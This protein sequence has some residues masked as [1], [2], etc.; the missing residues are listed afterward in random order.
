MKTGNWKRD[1]RRSAINSLCALM[2]VFTFASTRSAAQSLPNQ[3]WKTQ[4]TFLF[5]FTPDPNTG[6]AETFAAVQ[7]ALPRLYSE[8]IRNI[9]IYGP[10]EA[11]TQYSGLDAIE[12]AGLQSLGRYDDGFYQFSECRS[13]PRRRSDYI[14]RPRIRQPLE[15]SLYQRAG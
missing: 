10:Y 9:Q 12:L 5:L 3:W 6:A 14:F 8:G 15:Y 11:G 4:G 1:F 7:A 13:C 2:V